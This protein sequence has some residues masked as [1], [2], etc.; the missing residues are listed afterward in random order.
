MAAARACAHAALEDD[1]IEPRSASVAGEVVDVAGALG[2]DEAVAAAT[3]CLD[4]VGEDLFVAWLVLGERAVDAAMAPGR[5]DRRVTQCRNGVGWTTRSGG[6]GRLGA[7]SVPGSGGAN[8]WRTGPSWK[9]IRSSR[10]S[11]R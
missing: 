4:D 11:R 8:V 5:T 3:E 10:P 7:S 9:P 1:R 2:E 6:G